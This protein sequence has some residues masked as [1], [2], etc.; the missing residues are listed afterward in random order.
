MAKLGYFADVI[1]DAGVPILATI[2]VYDA[3]TA[4]KS[5]LWSDA[6]GTIVKD[7]P[8]QTD[9]LGRFVFFAGPGLYD[10]AVSGTGI[11]TYTVQSVSL[12]NITASSQ[13]T[14][15]PG[16]LGVPNAGKTPAVKGD[17]T[18]YELVANPAAHVLLSTSHSDSLAGTV[19][20][21]DLIHGNAT[22]KWARLAGNI[23][24]VKKFLTQTGSG[25]VSAVPAWAAILDADLPVTRT[26]ASPAADH[27]GVGILI[28]LTANEAQAIGD[29]CYIASDGKAKL[30]KGD[31]IANA[32]ALVMVSQAS[33]GSGAAGNY[34]LYGLVRDDSWSWTI[35]GKIY[36]SITG[37]TG[38]TLTQTAPTAANNVIQVVGVAL[39]AH[40]IMFR[41]NMVQVEHT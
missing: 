28:S 6:G 21:G 31:A 9:G 15:M 8:F 23:T 1:S 4:N 37:T 24:A 35:G 25:A 39:T 5:S 10:I 13:L 22:P 14:D 34:M 26:L 38:N 41:A 32:N 19:V 30:A 36:L 16:T 29:L 2:T 11:T 17:G 3:G 12:S 27:T 40:I 18:G 20:L 33:I 7:N